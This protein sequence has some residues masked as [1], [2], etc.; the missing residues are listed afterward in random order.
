[1]TRQEVFNKV[2]DWFIVQKNPQSVDY[3]E[4]D[5]KYRIFKEDKTLKCAIGCLIPDDLYEP[6]MDE[7]AGYNCKSLLLIYPTLKK[8]LDIKDED[9]EFLSDLQTAHDYDFH[10]LEGQLISIAK[11]YSVD[12]PK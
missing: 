7:G 2:W 11:L 10:R 9:F 6:K 1:M 3:E 4:E 8:T 5:C 12:V